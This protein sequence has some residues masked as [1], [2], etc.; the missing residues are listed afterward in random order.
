VIGQEWRAS[1]TG[2]PVQKGSLSR[3]VHRGGCKQG[4]PCPGHIA[5]QNSTALAKWRQILRKN[6]PDPPVVPW[7]VPVV[8]DL[9][10]YL[11]KPAKTRFITLPAVKPDLDKLARAILDVLTD[12][13]VYENDSRVVWL[14]VSKHW[15]NDLHRTPGVEIRVAPVDAKEGDSPD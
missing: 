11:T 14:K 4:H 1:V 9:A 6:L 12:I 15:A 10:F 2:E 5:A 8:V 13:G 3:F 7:D